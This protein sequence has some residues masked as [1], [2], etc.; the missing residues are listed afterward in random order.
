MKIRT[1]SNEALEQR[2]FDAE[3]DIKVLQESGGGGGGSSSPVTIYDPTEATY[4][5]D[6]IQYMIS[7]DKQV[8][9]VPYITISNSKVPAF[10]FG[11]FKKG[12][13]VDTNNSLLQFKY[14]DDTYGIKV[15]TTSDQLLLRD[16]WIT[17]VSQ[18][19]NDSAGTTRITFSFEPKS[20]NFGSGFK[21][22][23]T[24]INNETNTSIGTV[25]IKHS[26]IYKYTPFF[27]QSNAQGIYRD[28]T[29][30]FYPQS[31][32][33]SNLTAIIDTSTKIISSFVEEHNLFPRQY[34]LEGTNDGGWFN[35]MLQKEFIEKEFFGNGYPY[36]KGLLD[37]S[38]DADA[39]LTV[40]KN[41]GQD[42]AA[43]MRTTYDF[44][45]C[46][47]VYDTV[48]SEGYNIT[49]AAFISPSDMGIPINQSP[50]DTFTYK[51]RIILA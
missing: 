43:G 20:I 12:D 32:T 36:I 11:A 16:T 18:E 21:M 46:G 15:V 41:G 8:A 17:V 19:V 31:R 49:E 40:N 27:N 22:D 13:Y 30:L 25:S 3:K 51:S 42:Y 9:F 6:L 38:V 26:D 35:P 7:N 5:S 47:W 2:I 29:S 37:A 39:Y 34:I 1:L 10:Q 45:G 50:S 24:V 48:D 14:G 4:V 23:V 44:S 33:E 28:A